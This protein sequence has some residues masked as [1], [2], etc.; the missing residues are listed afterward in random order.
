MVSKNVGVYSGGYD[1]ANWCLTMRRPMPNHML[2]PIA[3]Y[4]CCWSYSCSDSNAFHERRSATDNLD[5]G[6]LFLEVDVF[7]PRVGFQELFHEGQQVSV[8]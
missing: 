2:A 4:S 1:C 7:A 3:V 6:D 8:K 5:S